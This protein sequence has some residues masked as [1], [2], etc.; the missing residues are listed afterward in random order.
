MTWSIQSIWRPTRLLEVGESLN[1][2]TGVTEVTTDAGHAYLKTLGNRQ[3][4]HV[5]ATDW[6][7]THL[8][9]WLGLST[10]DIAILPLAAEDVFDLPHEAKALPGPAFASRA[11]PGAPWGSS[12]SELDNLVNPEDITR[13]VVFDTWTRN[14]DR[15]PPP[16]HARQP[17]YDNVFLSTLDVPQGQRRLIAMD[18][19]LCF[20]NS[21][22]D[23]SPRLEH[24]RKIKD[25]RL[26]GLFCGFV[27]RLCP[28]TLYDCTE[29]L[30]EM[31]HD[32]A[33]AIVSTIP[34]EWDVS[35]SARTAWVHLIC[36]RAIFVADNIHRWLND[37]SASCF[38]SGEN[39]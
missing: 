39:E 9:K 22:E 19:G 11:V 38:L 36:R 7:G 5:L 27:G 37:A 29:R 3:G 8:A 13:I 6:V 26:Y 2:S 15:H 4:P 1:T 18:H 10:F 30:R 14:C 23:L 33:K 28:R 35:V 34:S 32:T 12:A 31:D 20:I 24:I 16:G 21:G 25:E 17:N